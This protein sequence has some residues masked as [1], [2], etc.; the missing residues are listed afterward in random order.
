MPTTSS[1]LLSSISDL[2]SPPLPL[3]Y[4]GSACSLILSDP[5]SSLSPQPG[6]LCGPSF[7][8]LRHHSYF[9]SVWEASHL[10]S[11]SLKLYWADGQNRDVGYCAVNGCRWTD[12]QRSVVELSVRPCFTLPV[13][14][15]CCFY[16]T[17]ICALPCLEA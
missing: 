1:M 4:G 2:L 10:G 14:Y 11:Q 16:S 3:S 8:P 17:Q 12:K 6:A 13:I 5:N 7:S 15:R 9:L